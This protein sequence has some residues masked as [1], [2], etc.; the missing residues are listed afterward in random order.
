MTV[1]NYPNHIF[2][3]PITTSS[4]TTT[5]REDRNVYNQLINL[6]RTKTIR[7]VNVYE[8][9]KRLSIGEGFGTT[10]SVTGGC[11]RDIIMGREAN[12]FDLCFIAEFKHLKNKLL[13]I[14]SELG[15][16]L[17]EKSLVIEK[18]SIC[19]MMIRNHVGIDA[20]PNEMKEPLDIVICKS[21]RVDPNWTS[22]SLMKKSLVY[23]HKYLMGNSYETDSKTRDFTINSLYIEPFSGH[24]YIIDPSGNGYNDIQNKILRLTS[25]DENEFKG[26]LGALFRYWKMLLEFPTFTPAKDQDLTK[27]VQNYLSS[28]IKNLEMEQTEP[29]QL[30]KKFLVKLQ[31]KLFRTDTSK[32]IE[33]FHQFILSTLGNTNNWWIDL[34]RY[35]Q[36]DQAKDKYNSFLFDV[37]YSVI[38]MI[39]KIISSIDVK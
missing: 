20:G 39:K 11:I 24:P 3:T 30:N 8:L 6:L 5:F 31:F 36:T 2:Y 25:D 15:V 34:I 12:D 29:Y 28:H 19:H 14:F 37:N 38:E 7:S 32:K 35:L 13:E 4:T 21:N 10:F 33:I 27:L 9:L 17:S 1:S 16:P 23:D 26:D 22:L 18:K